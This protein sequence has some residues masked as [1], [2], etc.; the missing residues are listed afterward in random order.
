[1]DI[2]R[3]TID[4]VAQKKDYE[5]LVKSL[6]EIGFCNG[7]IQ[8]HDYE[9][10]C[11][12]YDENKFIVLY[13]N[14][15]PIGFTTWRGELQWAIVDYK[16]ILPEYRGVGIGRK[17]SELIY[18]EFRRRVI[19]FIL[20]QPATDNGW[21]MSRSF[22]FKPH[23]ESDYRYSTNYQ[24]LFLRPNRKFSQERNNGYELLI[25]HNY[26]YLA[27][28]AQVYKLD[29]TLTVNPIISIVDYDAHVELRKDGEV[30]RRNVAKRFFKESELQGYGLLYFNTNLSD[31]RK[32]YNL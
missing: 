17:F 20:A 4:F 1:M 32:E 27:E 5:I 29:E 13:Y 23:N 12:S 3:L 28:P 9:R 10:I 2:E 8:P 22:G 18:D 31:Y 25:W 11:K 14:H 6:R 15:I 26:N 7:I 16:W 30:I 24:Y 21:G 19:Y